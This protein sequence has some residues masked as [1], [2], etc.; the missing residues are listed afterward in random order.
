MDS[1]YAE[2]HSLGIKINL[3]NQKWPQAEYSV[4][5]VKE[6]IISGSRTNLHQMLANL[7]D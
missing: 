5:D 6:T 3:R 2:S 7:G 4:P 1:T